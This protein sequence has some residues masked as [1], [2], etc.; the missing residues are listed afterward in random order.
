MVELV[1]QVRMEQPFAYLP[2]RMVVQ[3]T[4]VEI[5][6]FL[7]KVV[8]ELED[9]RVPLPEE[10]LKLELVVLVV[11]LQELKEMVVELV[12]L[13]DL[14]Q[15]MLPVVL[16]AVLLVILELVEPVDMAILLLQA[17]MD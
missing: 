17:Q 9:R 13:V 8:V 7:L 10:L 16:A 4:F 12:E 15:S 5:L 14:L 1:V 2:G 6:L 3:V 11:L